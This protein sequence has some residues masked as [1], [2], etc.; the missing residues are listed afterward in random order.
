MKGY[1]FLSQVSSY[2]GRAVVF[3]FLISAL[4]F[5]VYLLG[6]YQDFLDSTQ[7][8]LL[9]LLRVALS[10]ELLTGAWLAVLLVYRGI[11]ERRVLAVRWVLLILSLFLCGAL[12]AALRMVQQW[13]QS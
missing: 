7:S 12:L 8:T 2:T 10:L 6:N 11:S 1:R 13:L 9:S 4:L 3:F 5:F